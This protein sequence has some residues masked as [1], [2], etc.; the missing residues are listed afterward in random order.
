M[1]S[2]HLTLPVGE[3]NLSTLRAVRSGQIDFQ[4]AVKLIETAETRL[5]ELVDACIW[6]ADIAGIDEFLVQAHIRH[7]VSC[8]TMPARTPF[9]PGL[10][11][12]ARRT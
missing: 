6:S 10:V 7:W 3:P 11:Q 8:G 5:R 2:R 4:A 1:T 9:V 12:A